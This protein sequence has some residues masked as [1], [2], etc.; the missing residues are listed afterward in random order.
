MVHLMTMAVGDLRFAVPASTVRTVVRAVA[1]TALPDAPPSVEGIINFRGSLV[2]VLSVR[3]RVRLA[4]LPLSLDQHLVI[5]RSGPRTVGLRVDH[6]IDL[7]S[8]DE[9][10]IESAPGVLPGFEQVAGL[11]TLPDGLIVIYDLERFLSREEG[12]LVD[13]ALAAAQPA[14][15]DGASLGPGPQRVT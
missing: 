3:Q 12:G 2:P 11:A 1:V 7:V 15:R 6:V 4:S 5:A 14:P 13:A 9:S 10:A 8:V